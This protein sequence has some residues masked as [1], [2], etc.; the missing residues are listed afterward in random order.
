MVDQTVQSSRAVCDSANASFIGNFCK[1]ELD[2]NAPIKDIL[3]SLLLCTSSF[4]ILLWLSFETGWPVAENSVRA[5]C[6]PLILVGTL[7]CCFS[8]KSLKLTVCV[9]PYWYSLCLSCL[10]CKYDSGVFPCSQRCE[11]NSLNN[12]YYMIQNYFQSSMCRKT[13]VLGT[14]G[15]LAV[16][17]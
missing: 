10:L 11:V 1:G 14:C 17:F 12:L 5:K 4:L 16:L 3:L 15:L 6:S 13:I 9:L 2:C 8:L 7:L